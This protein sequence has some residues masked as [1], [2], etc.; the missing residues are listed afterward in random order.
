M[1]LLADL[2]ALQGGSCGICGAVRTGRDLVLDHDH[3]SGFVRGLLCLNCNRVEGCHG[4][5][6]PL[7]AATCSICRWRATPAV[8]WLGYTERYES[9]FPIGG[10]EQFRASPWSPSA[11]R[12]EFT[13]AAIRQAT[14]AA[15][16]RA[17]EL[18]P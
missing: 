6:E 8:S 1:S 15:A 14:N 4:R 16:A 17:A 5:C 3:A 18:A 2:E 10:E 11:E 9:S 13:R 12:A 7:D